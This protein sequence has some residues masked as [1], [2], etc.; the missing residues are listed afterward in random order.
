MLA[1]L[2]KLTNPR[3]NRGRVNR[4]AAGLKPAQEILMTNA[5]G[6][7]IARPSAP[8]PD[9]NGFNACTYTTTCAA[10]TSN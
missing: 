10:P 5:S 4:A 8:D 7:V 3:F 1:P 6:V 9:A 2:P